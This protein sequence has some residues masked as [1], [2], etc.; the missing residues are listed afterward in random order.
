MLIPINPF[1]TYAANQL[2]Y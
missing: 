1:M 2:N